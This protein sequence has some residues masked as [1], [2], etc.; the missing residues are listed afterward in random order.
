MKNISDPKIEFATRLRNLGFSI[1]PVAPK[2]SEEPEFT[3][4]NPSYITQVASYLGLR[5]KAVQ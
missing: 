5:E 3:G 4:K 2:Q 1:L